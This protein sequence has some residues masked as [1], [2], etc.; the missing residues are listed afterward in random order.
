M[1]VPSTN[2]STSWV[3]INMDKCFLIGA[4]RTFDLRNLSVYELFIGDLGSSNKI[5]TAKKCLSG[6]MS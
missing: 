3:W 6:E 4:F 2:I 1:T 5:S